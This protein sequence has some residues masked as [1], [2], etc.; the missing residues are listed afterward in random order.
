MTAHATTVD[1]PSFLDDRPKQ[2]LIG[3]KR[4]S[5]V[6]GKSSPCITDHVK[7]VWINTGS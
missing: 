2:M 3:G 5:A 7:G 6:A 4:V 1:M